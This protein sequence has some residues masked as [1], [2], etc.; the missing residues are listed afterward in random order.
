MVWRGGME[1]NGGERRGEKGW[2][3]MVGRGEEKRVGG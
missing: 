3:I 2:R 1:D